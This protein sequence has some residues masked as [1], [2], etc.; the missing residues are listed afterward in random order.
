MTG[1]SHRPS[2]FSVKFTS[3]KC[4]DHLQL[5]GAKHGGKNNFKKQ[6]NQTIN[7]QTSNNHRNKTYRRW[8]WELQ[9][10]MKHDETQKS[11]CLR[12]FLFRL[13]FLLREAVVVSQFTRLADKL[14][15]HHQQD[16]VFQPGQ[17][18]KKEGCSSFR[19]SFL[20]KTPHFD[21]FET[22][23]YIKTSKKKLRLACEWWSS[24]RN[25]PLAAL[26]PR[27]HCRTSMPRSRSPGFFGR[28][29]RPFWSS[30]GSQL[31]TPCQTKHYRL[32]SLIT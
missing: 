6:I 10:R 28:S 32:A 19:A 18:C 12:S 21:I 15:V 31:E 4:W 5:A 8:C 1:P 22:W 24:S 29:A 26:G 9:V 23:N 20:R 17:G 3:C 11:M 27:T 13:S 30:N 25:E 2:Y 7:K 14:G 16:G